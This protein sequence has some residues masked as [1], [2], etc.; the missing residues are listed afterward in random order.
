M[1]TVHLKPAGCRG[2]HRSIPRASARGIEDPSTRFGHDRTV[3]PQSWGALRVVLGKTLNYYLRPTTRTDV[4]DRSAKCV[5]VADDQRTWSRAEGD[6]YSKVQTIM[7]A[8]LALHRHDARWSRTRVLH[9]GRPRTE[10][11]PSPH[12]VQCVWTARDGPLAIGS[13]TPLYGP[14]GHLKALGRQP[15]T[16]AGCIVRD[17]APL[18]KCTHGTPW[19]GRTPG[20]TVRTVCSLARTVPRGGIILTIRRIVREGKGLS[21]TARGGAWTR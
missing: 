21:C 2:R 6:A 20:R 10:S 13:M 1:A 7:S 9:S 16:G 3:R 11:V 17:A 8:L 4:A 15:G 12:R 14:R 5:L 19:A 18:E